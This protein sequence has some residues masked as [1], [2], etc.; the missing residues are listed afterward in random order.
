MCMNY[1]T[2]PGANQSIQLVKRCNV[3][4]RVY[5]APQFW[6]NDES[7]VAPRSLQQ[8]PL[9]SIINT[10]N[11]R[12]FIL[13]QPIQTLDRQQC[14]LLRTADNQPCDYVKHPDGLT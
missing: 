3:R 2:S 12:D 7:R 13:R 6:K 4:Q 14:V 1:V 8:V 11:E 10:S 9:R 5:A